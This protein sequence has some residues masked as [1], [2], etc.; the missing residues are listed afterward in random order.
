MFILAA[1]K[2]F[3]IANKTV[4]ND[5]PIQRVAFLHKAKTLNLWN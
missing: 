5:S 2:Y 3:I 4:S 1:M